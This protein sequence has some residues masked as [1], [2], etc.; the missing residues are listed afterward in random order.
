[1]FIH[2]NIFLLFIIFKSVL[3][4]CVNAYLT[5]PIRL[6]LFLFLCFFVFMVVW[7]CQINSDK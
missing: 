3:N 2:S 4:V 7:L 6:L 5:I 1:M